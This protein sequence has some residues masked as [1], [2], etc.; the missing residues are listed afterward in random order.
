MHPKASLDAVAKKKSA[1]LKTEPQSTQRNIFMST[2]PSKTILL[3]SSW[4]L[5]GRTRNNSMSETGSGRERSLPNLRHK[6]S[7]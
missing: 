5:Q 7:I 3:V 4:G 6:P 1:V 2:L